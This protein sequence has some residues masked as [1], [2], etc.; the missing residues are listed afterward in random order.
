[1]SSKILH[2]EWD[3]FSLNVM[4]DGASNMSG[5]RNGVSKN[6][7]LEE[8]VKSIHTAMVDMP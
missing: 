8:S 1:M 3:S 7:L 2:F 4:I 5:I 6:I